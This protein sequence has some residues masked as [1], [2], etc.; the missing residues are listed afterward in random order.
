MACYMKFNFYLTCVGCLG[1]SLII[2]KLKVNSE[3]VVSVIKIEYHVLILIVKQP[4]C[5]PILHLF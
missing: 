1:T 5:M 2:V 4:D 3:K